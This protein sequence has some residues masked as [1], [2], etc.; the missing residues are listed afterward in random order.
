MFNLAFQLSAVCNQLKKNSLQIAALVACLFAIHPMH[1]ESVCW[2]SDLKDLLFTMF[3]LSSLIYYIKYI[4]L[5][6]S[7]SWF[8]VPKLKIKLYFICLFLFVCACLS[9]SAAVTFP[10][11]MILTDYLLNSVKFKVLSVK[12]W[13]R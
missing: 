3:Y 13:M 7:S 12:N 6:V 9:K 10:L 8:Q 2:A 5:R 4:K 1:C 11:I